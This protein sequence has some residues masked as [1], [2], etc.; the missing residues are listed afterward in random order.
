MNVRQT[1]ASAPTRRSTS[2]CT[3]GRPRA[4][5]LHPLC[6]LFA[7]LDLA[8]EVTRRPRRG[9][10]DEVRLPRASRATTSPRARSRA[11]RAAAPDVPL[12]PLRIEIQKRIPVAAGLGGGSADAA[13]VLRAANAAR[14]RARSTPDE[15]RAIG[16]AARLRRSEPDRAAPRARDR[17]RRAGRTGRPAGD[18]R[19][20]SFPQD[21]GLSTGRG[22]RRARPPRVSGR[23]ADGLDRRAPPAT[24]S[25]QPRAA[26]PA[27]S[28]ARRAR[29]DLQP[30]ALSLRPELTSRSPPC[31]TP[32]RSPPQVTGSGPTSFGLFADRARRRARRRPR[33]TAQ[34]AAA[35]A[36][37]PL[38]APRARADDRRGAAVRRRVRRR[39]AGAA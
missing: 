22:L 4:D 24:G 34:R 12:P 7:S 26:A 10:A 16:R 13:A 23:R 18:R 2:C 15:L 29:N 20:C 6:S 17:G 35:C 5:G 11:F 38:G 30:A 31:A 39:G 37:R 27:R 21:E 25:R 14:R 3:S 33:S 9:A 36:A 1:L 19:W 28:P 8:D 32:A